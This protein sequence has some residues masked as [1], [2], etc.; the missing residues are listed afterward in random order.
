MLQKC[1]NWSNGWIHHKTLPWCSLSPVH[2]RD[3]PALPGL[4][5]CSLNEYHLAR[6]GKNRMLNYTEI[7]IANV[8][9]EAA[10]TSIGN[11]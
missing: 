4:G 3:L 11:G 1:E 8:S 7:D 9:Q 5:T 10:R 2:L 6:R